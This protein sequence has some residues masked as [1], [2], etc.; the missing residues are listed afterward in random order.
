MSL[1]L[2]GK[3]KSILYLNMVKSGMESNNDPSQDEFCTVS[4]R[5]ANTPFLS[6]QSKYLCAV[7]RFSVPLM[8]VHT[9]ADTG[10]TYFS[11]TDADLD[12]IAAQHTDRIDE[13]LE[14]ADKRKE[15]LDLME[16]GVA[17]PDGEPYATAKASGQTTK[18]FFGT[19]VD[20]K[21]CFS[22]Y[23]FLDKIQQK[24]LATKIDPKYNLFLNGDENGGGRA[25]GHPNVHDMIAITP[26]TDTE[27]A[28]IV[29][30][31]LAE[32]MTLSLIHI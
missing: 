2:G 25:A 23:E 4:S 17:L 5:F 22:F 18:D 11:Y 12:A 1:E 28:K 20:I 24:L 19:R 32:R 15:A 7:T 13:K 3:N 30:H 8:Q 29:F 16:E 14:D 6:D 27:P 26:A 21:A 9:I 10:F 31:P